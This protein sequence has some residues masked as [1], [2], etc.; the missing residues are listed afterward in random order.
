MFG[1]ASTRDVVGLLVV[2]RWT[3]VAGQS[4]AVFAVAAVLGWD[5]PVVALAAGITLL[6]VFNVVAALRLRLVAEP[7]SSVEVFVHMSVDVSLLSYMLALTGG[8]SNPFFPL[9][10]VP[11]ALAALAL[12]LPWVFATAATTLLCATLAVFVHLPLPPGLAQ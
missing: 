5:I 4:G 6:A 1:F 10:L 11:I 3:A 8:P 2:L 7:F 12:A 9:L